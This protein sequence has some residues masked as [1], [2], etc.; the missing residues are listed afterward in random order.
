MIVKKNTEKEGYIT[1]YLSLSILVMLSLLFAL[2]EGIRMQTI[3]FQT[4]CVMDIGLNS[5]FAEYHQ[6]LLEQY[7]LF[8]IDTTY[9]YE[10][11]DVNRTESHLL[12]YMNM[13]F[14]VPGKDRIPGYKDL[15]AIHADNAGLS[16]ISY[17]SDGEGMV[18]KY[19]IIQYMKEKS[20]LSVADSFFNDEFGKSEEQFNK[21][22]GERKSTKGNIKKILELLNSER[23]EEENEISIDNPADYIDGMRGSPI[24]SYAIRDSSGISGSRVS[25]ENYISHRNYKK[26]SS[27]WKGQSLPD[28]ISDKILF[29]KYL[30]EKCGYYQEK[31]KQGALEYQLEYLLYGKGSDIENISDFAEQL[32]QI[33]Y[34]INAA[35]LF[36]SGSKKAEAGELAAVVTAGIMSPELYEAVKLTILFAWCYA[37]TAQDI[38]ILFDGKAVAKIK[39]DTTWNIQLSELLMFTSSLDSYKDV[40][41]GKTYYDYLSALLYAKD[42]NIVRM[43]LMDIMEMDI[44]NTYGNSFF[45]MDACIYQLNATVNISSRYGYAYSI[46]RNYSY[47]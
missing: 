10:A 36:A 34:V 45:M 14:N 31:K 5:I 26:G 18:L 4:E 43:R 30:E 46:V 3:R 22:E 28:G 21:L 32:F 7:D 37:E 17:L 38:R 39:N 25:L 42:E 41:G 9:G 40:P 24:L 2:I 33:R 35:Y 16:D 23:E 8:A 44:R 11:A 20:G 19:Q 15:T 12:Q 47:E 13:N 27:L 29:H 1:V 6:E